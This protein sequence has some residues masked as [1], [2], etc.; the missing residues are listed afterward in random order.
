MTSDLSDRFRLSLST[1]LKKING[2][3]EDPSVL[4]ACSGG[5]DSL[6]LL[7]LLAEVSERLGLRIGA[8]YVNHKLREE[9]SEEAGFVKR[10]CGRLKI[11]FFLNEFDDAFW[12]GSR[13]NVEERARNKRYEMLVETAKK[14][15]FTAI[16][17]AHQR[18][19]QVETVLMKMLD[20]GCGLK[21][22]GGIA[23]LHEISGIFII[24]PLLQFSR[25]ELAAYIGKRRFISDPSNSD[26]QI[27][28]NFYR[29][30]I[31]PMLTETLKSDQFE[32][33]IARSAANVRREKAVLEQFLIRFWSDKLSGG[34]ILLR[35]NLIRA[36]DADFWMTAFSY[37]FS[38][39]GQIFGRETAADSYSPSTNTL[40]DITNFVVNFGKKSASYRPFLLVSDS[41]GVKIE[42]DKTTF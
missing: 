28:R 39:S 41:D 23:Q 31:V 2:F 33:N 1:L 29:K 10:V 3:S 13:K 11:P 21:G 37:L 17:T 26:E 9:A 35:K 34:R 14:E 30:K 15:G 32:A 27:R 19:D 38:C 12:S 6:A 24:R 7:L 22:L 16:T 20:R 40:K 4:V 25:N 18:D 8:S 36:H 42:L 5:I